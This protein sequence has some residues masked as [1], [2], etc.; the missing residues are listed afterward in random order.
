[1]PYAFLENASPPRE[2]PATFA[3][4]GDGSSYG[5]T[6]RQFSRYA[7]PPGL[8][9]ASGQVVAS[10]AE[11]PEAYRNLFN[12]AERQQRL[13]GNIV[14]EM[15]AREEV[16]D[17]RIRVV[18]EATGVELENPHRGG[19]RQEAMRRIRE[20]VRQNGFAPI[21]GSGGV[22]AYQ[23]RIFDE[24]LAEVQ[25]ANPDKAAAFTAWDI[26]TEARAIARG[27]TS[28]LARAEAADGLDPMA[29][30]A[31][32]FAGAL[33]GQRRDPLFTGSLFVG[34][35][36]AVGKAALTRVA[37]SSLAQGTFN[38]GLAA[39][40]QPVVQQWRAEVGMR[41]GIVPAVE[42][43]GMA[44][45]FG[46]IPGAAIQGIREASRAALGRIKVGDPLPGD[47]AEVA[48]AIGAPLSPRDAAAVRIGEEAIQADRALLTQPAR[49]V[50][51]EAHNDLTAA[52]LKHAEDPSQPSPAAL[53]F[54]EKVPSDRR[55]GDIEPVETVPS[56]MAEIEHRV[57]TSNSQSLAEART[58]A[59][60][61][62][63]EAGERAMGA[64]AR[65]ELDQ[66]IYV[67]PPEPVAEAPKLP[68][69]DPLGKVALVRDD[70]TVNLVSREAVARQGERESTFADLVRSCK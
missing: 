63:E 66:P 46:A 47:I 19:Y 51:P 7:S 2:A 55:F 48:D 68:R 67:P 14:S 36:S 15:A 22:P 9:V 26:D 28:D 70:G 6:V 57:A 33:W 27:A 4:P 29:K 11:K 10:V 13:T 35:T 53:L 62:M 49:G 16:Y 37:T 30:F 65:D 61:A 20:E 25:N 40:E 44:F 59:S 17:Q 45:L 58:V 56:P 23:K 50:T 8:L 18:K 5:D 12:A 69:S 34:P 31:V 42:E 52:A 54:E 21:E 43:V 64:R 60:D 32:S 41:S 39:L 24:K 38:M 1:M 3:E